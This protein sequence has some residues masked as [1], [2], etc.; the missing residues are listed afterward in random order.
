MKRILFRSSS[1]RV[2]ELVQRD[3]KFWNKGKESEVKAFQ[4]RKNPDTSFVLRYR[5]VRVFLLFF[6]IEKEIYDM[7]RKI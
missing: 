3:R 6:L 4:S 7:P 2:E 1:V 5:G